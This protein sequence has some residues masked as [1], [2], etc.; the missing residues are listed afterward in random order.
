MVVFVVDTSLAMAGSKLQSSKDGVIGAIDQ[1]YERNLVG[2]VTFSNSVH[3]KIVPA[4]LAQNRFVLADAIRQAQVGSGSDLFDAIAQ[5]IN[6]AA[7]APAPEKSIRGVV[8]LAGGPANSGSSLSDLVSMAA[9]GKQIRTCRGF[10]GETQCIDEDGRTVDR[11]AVTG[12]P[13]TTDGAAAIKVYFIGIG[14]SDTD[15]QVGRI[16]AEAT[17]SNF[18]GTTVKDLSAV[19]GVFKGYF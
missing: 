14:V 1:M 12:V 17:R 5:G 4:P 18:V 7:T 16:L 8:V 9:G 15:L 19:V 11:S 10:E 6:M 13:S 3:Q 2:L